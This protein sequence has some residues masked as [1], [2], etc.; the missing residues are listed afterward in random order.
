V[1]RAR[2]TVELRVC[3]AGAGV[4]EAERERVFEPFHRAS[5]TRQAT[6]TGLGLALVQAIARQHGGEARCAGAGNC[7]SVTLPD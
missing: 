6:G 5:G 4:T 2:G 1:R 3:D 7:F